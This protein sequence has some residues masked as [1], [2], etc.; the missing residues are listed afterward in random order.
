MWNLNMLVYYLYFR[1]QTG[2]KYAYT[3]KKIHKICI[4][5][6][7]RYVYLTLTFDLD[8]GHNFILSFD[9]KRVYAVAFLGEKKM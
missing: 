2:T 9:L 1:F 4:F 5:V 3:Y 7:W 8:K 6:I